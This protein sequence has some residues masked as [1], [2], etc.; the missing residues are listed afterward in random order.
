MLTYHHSEVE[1]TVSYEESHE[2]VA[3]H[4]LAIQTLNVILTKSSSETRK[5]N[6]TDNEIEINA[7]IQVAKCLIKLLTETCILP[8]L[9]T[10]RKFYV[11]V[12][13]G[14]LGEC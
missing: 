8:S 6:G 4:Q 10:S 2:C 7:H 1:T 3:R 11:G 5:V 13:R 9:N 14:V 12:R